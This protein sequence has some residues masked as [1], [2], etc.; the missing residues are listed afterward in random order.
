[1]D[2]SRCSRLPS[3]QSPPFLIFYVV[4]AFA[5]SERGA[6]WWRLKSQRQVMAPAAHRQAGTSERLEVQLRPI[7]LGWTRGWEENVCRCEGRPPNSRNLRA[8]RVREST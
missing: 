6:S 4:D 2:S 5:E 7:R 1:V 8:S 3:F